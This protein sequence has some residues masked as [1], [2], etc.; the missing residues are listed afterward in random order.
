MNLVIENDSYA[1][2][3]EIALRKKRFVKYAEKS[4]LWQGVIVLIMII[5]GIA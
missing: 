4:N 2:K 1:T 3:E 5:F